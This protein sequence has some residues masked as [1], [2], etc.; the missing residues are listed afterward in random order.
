MAAPI[1]MPSTNIRKVD[2]IA[3]MPISLPATQP[4][5]ARMAVMEMSM[6]PTSSTHSMPQD[7]TMLMEPFLRT[8]M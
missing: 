2:S 8:F 4:T 6:E 5:K 7:M 3:P 1:A